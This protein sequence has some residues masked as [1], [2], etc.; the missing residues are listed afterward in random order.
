[1]IRSNVFLAIIIV[2]IAVAAAVPIDPI[3]ATLDPRHELLTEIVGR[4]CS[5]CIVRHQLPCLFV[6]I[7]LLLDIF[8]IVN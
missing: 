4:Y 8:V 6:D 2:L 7:V 3:G 5:F 1:M